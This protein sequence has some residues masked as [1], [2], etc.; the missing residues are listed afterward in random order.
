TL[1]LCRNVRPTDAS[2]ATTDSSI[3]RVML[4]AS[5]PVPFSHTSAYAPQTTV[6]VRPPATSVRGA[7]QCAVAV[8]EVVI[9]ST[10]IVMVEMPDVPAVKIPCSSTVP[11]P[12][13]CQAGVTGTLLP[14]SSNAVP[15]NA[16]VSR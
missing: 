15:E 10:S 11:A 3:V 5:S 4:A 1:S 2:T 6:K 9:P 14:H 8:A 13:T 7:A 12:V 16:T